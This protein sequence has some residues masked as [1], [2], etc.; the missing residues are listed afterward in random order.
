MMWAFFFICFYNTNFL[1]LLYEQV[2]LSLRKGKYKLTSGF[3]LRMEYLRI[4]DFS[5]FHLTIACV[6]SNMS[7]SFAL[8]RGNTFE[9]FLKNRL[10]KLGSSFYIWCDRLFLYDDTF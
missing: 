1:I 8:L 6:N 7:L 4:C 2:N 9:I 10:P 5:G 3:L